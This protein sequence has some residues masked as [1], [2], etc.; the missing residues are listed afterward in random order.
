MRLWAL[1]AK[2]LL[3]LRRDWHALLLLFVMPTLFIVIMSL[4]LRDTFAG[5]ATVSL[6]YAL[7]DQDGSPRARAVASAIRSN[8]NFAEAGLGAGQEALE[9]QVKGDALHFLVVFPK[10]FGAAM[11]SARPL[12]LEIYTAPRVEPAISKLFEAGLREALARVYIGIQIVAIQKQFSGFLKPAAIGADLDLDAV[13]RLLSHAA[14]PGEELRLP[15]S[16]QQN[17][18][19][20]LI[21]AMFFIAIPLSTTW[22]QES[23]QGTLMRLRSMGLGPGL[24]IFGKL[25]PYVLVNLL[26]VA[27]MLVVGA[28]LV[29]MLGG[30]ALGLGHSPAALMLMALALSFAS[31]SYAL[32]I[33]NI[34]ATTEQATIF[35]G[36]SNLL[37]AAL[38]GVMVPRFVMPLAM[39][40][41]SLAS[42][43]AWGL[44]G[45]LDVFLR[46]R[47]LPEVAPWA[48]LLFAFGLASLGLATLSL[49]RRR[50]R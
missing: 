26:Q 17:V 28:K 50:G 20:W 33:A 12:P 8:K 32:L 6:T 9:Q 24:L 18:P 44:E 2:E 19:A 22:V 10:G 47:G 1:I 23:G 42:P 7:L 3:L 27:L 11:G 29:P 45:F 21:F 34:A 48:G 37:L 14:V 4:A 38:G 30:D 5:H 16:V 43:M 13:D 46:Q 39:Q 25:L 40:K 31:V 35:T 15:S 49:G 41:I 36:V